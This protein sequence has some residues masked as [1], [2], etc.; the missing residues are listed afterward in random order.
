VNQTATSAAKPRARHRSAHSASSSKPR[1]TRS[2]VAWPRQSVFP[3]VCAVQQHAVMQRFAGAAT[4]CPNAS[5]SQF[6]GLPPLGLLCLRSPQPAAAGKSAPQPLAA[7][8]CFGAF[9]R[10]ILRTSTRL[11]GLAQCC[12]TPRSSGPPTAGRA[13]SRALGLRP[14]LRPAAVTPCRRGP[15]S[16]NVRPHEST[17]SARRHSNSRPRWLRCP[18]SSERPHRGAAPKV[19]PNPRVS[20]NNCCMEVHHAT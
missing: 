16:S 9:K 10:G 18:H 19:I 17:Q 13:H 4:S 3:S 6:V 12:L 7:S 15:L 14:I 8:A 20:S 11:L 2:P 1:N 5:V